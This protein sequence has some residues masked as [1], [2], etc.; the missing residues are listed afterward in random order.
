MNQRKQG[1]SILDG[2]VIQSLTQPIYWAGVP[3]ELFIINLFIAVLMVMIFHFWYFL[4]I[5][6]IA[7][8]IFVY[9]GKR[10]PL[11]YEIFFRYNRT[12][13]YYWS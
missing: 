11:F 2:R 10:E 9:L 3:R 1:H 8:L 5:S 6:G 4:M 7:H 12:K 13:K